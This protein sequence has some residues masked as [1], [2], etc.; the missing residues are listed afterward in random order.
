MICCRPGTRG[1]T[2][3]ISERIIFSVV[4]TAR[5]AGRKFYSVYTDEL[6]LLVAS[7]P[8]KDPINIP[9]G[10]STVRFQYYT[11]RSCRLRVLVPQ[12][13]PTPLA[14]C[15]TGLFCYTPSNMKYDHRSPILNISRNAAWIIFGLSVLPMKIY[16]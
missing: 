16:T 9:L 15:N 6:Q 1:Y 8:E 7:D 3:S 12:Q 13:F 5:D 11:T 14:T 2:I 10:V 4:D